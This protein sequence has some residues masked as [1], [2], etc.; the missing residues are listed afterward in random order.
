MPAGEI[1]PEYFPSCNSPVLPETVDSLMLGGLIVTILMY[2]SRKRGEL[3]EHSLSNNCSA[4]NRQLRMSQKE[5]KAAGNAGS[6]TFVR[7]PLLRRDEHCKREGAS[8]TGLALEVNLPAHD[9][10]QPAGDV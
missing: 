2:D 6:P 7:I 8:P 9:F 1:P 3:L 10:N 4:V 5:D